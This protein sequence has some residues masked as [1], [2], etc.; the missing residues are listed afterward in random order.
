MKNPLRFIGVF[1]LMFCLIALPMFAGGKSQSASGGGGTTTLTFYSLAEWVASEPYKAAYDAAKAEF[2]QT[3]PGFRI[4]L[5]SDPWNDWQ[6]K[7]KTMFASGNPADIMLVNNPDFP[8]F[9]NSGYLLEL[10]NYVDPNYF[11]DFFP[12]VL[13]MYT[14]RGKYLGFPNS[15]GVK[16]LWYNKDLF[17]QAGLDPEKPPTTWAELVS[18]ATA[19]T[20]KTGKYGFGMDLALQ[21]FPTESLYDTTGDYVLKVDS[22]GKVTSNVNTPAFK[23]YL[24]CLLDLKP[25]F[26]PD[27]AVTE[28]HDA[29]RLF[30]EG[31]VGIIFHGTLLETDI[32]TRGFPYGQGLI[33][34]Q[35]AS[36]QTASYAGGFC[37]AVSKQTKAPKEA[38]EF[39]QLLCSPK[40]NA[41]SISDPPASNAAL[42]AWEYAKD[43]RLTVFMEQMK[44]GRRAQPTTMYYNEVEAA[45]R[46]TVVDV[47]V[48]GKGIDAAIADLDKKV[49]QIVSN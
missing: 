32:Y 4:E 13:E 15:T 42:A 1:C 3:H 23:A 33:P 27:F 45:I 46:D 16:I 20:Q 26:Q 36:G 10:E 39:A 38:V 21:Y 29:S 22:S 19:I 43:P 8:G 5:Q 6:S 41:A 17:R 30:R 37:L 49:T 28:Y 2:E 34:K 11:K 7:Y 44:T 14:W 24:Q 40:Y 31:Q 25:S 35:T 9:A 48:N 18:Y 12:G 47:L